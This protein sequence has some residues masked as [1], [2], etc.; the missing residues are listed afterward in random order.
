MIPKKDFYFIRHGQ[1]DHNKSLTKTDHGD[2]SLNLIGKEQARNIAPLVSQ[3][4]LQTICCS[5]LKRAKETKELM[6]PE[7]EHIELDALGECTA[8]IWSEMTSLHADAYRK[9]SL[10]TRNFLQR[11]KHGLNQALEQIGPVLIVAHGG[12]HFAICHW[13]NI[14]GHS[15]VIDN[16]QLV[17]FS[18]DKSTDEWKAELLSSALAGREMETSLKKESRV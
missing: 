7:R 9:G 4:P 10:V 1:T 3:I 17:H 6:L 8:Q 13:M 14:P 16:C 15:W 11:V 2:I 5:P 18:T 12:V